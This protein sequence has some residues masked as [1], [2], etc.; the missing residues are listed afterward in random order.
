MTSVRTPAVG[1]R[2]TLMA[3]A[4]AAALGGF[5]LG[6]ELAVI[7]GALLFLRHDFSLTAFEQGALVSAVPLGA[8]AGGLVVGRVADALGRR[9]TLILVAV[10]FIAATVLAT[11]ASSYGVLLAARGLSGVAA[12]AG[13]STVPVYLS[14]IAPPERRGR[15][16][17]LN[18][19][20]ITIGIV[21]AYCV[22]LIFSGS[23]SWRAMFAMGLVPSALML[24][25]MVRAPETPA[26]LQAHGQPDKA[27]TVLREIVDGQSAER[28][29]EDFRRLN[30]EG[31]QALG[32]R[33]LLR[34]AA[35]P[36][37]LVAVALAVMQQF[38]GINAIIPY[39]PT[40][41]ERAGL[42]AS[43]SLLSSVLLGV[44]NVA[45][46]V[47]SFRLVDRSGRRPLLVTSALGAGVA[48]ALLGLTFEVSLS[49][50]GS[51]LPLL[52]L[53]AYIASFAIGLG[54]IF[55]LL[56]AE[57][58]PPEARAAG[59]GVATAVNWFSGFVVGLIFVPLSNAIGT[60]PTF[61]VFAGVCAVAIV[62]VKRY[63]PETKG[64]TFA[65][66]ME[67]MRARPAGDGGSAG[68]RGTA[69]RTAAG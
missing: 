34:S 67:E 45:A 21:A 55:W 14:E 46:T 7:S 28:V 57:I 36:A 6:Y 24:V 68:R 62:F 9:A 66:I 63:V 10:L 22:G 20:M 49:G 1:R 65:E 44:A 23:G 17:T 4:I 38:S 18:Q 32:L 60:G 53:L 39:A 15:L 48:L 52:F 11:T 13:S 35:A 8:M 69:G 64:R 29:L 30:R 16:V 54:P 61:W 25:G 33:A 26:W 37:L 12:G 40:I 19:L 2:R 3:W 42:T 59:A 31:A 56:I 27:E 47:I 5:V 43:N 50:A 41:M 58:F 51:W